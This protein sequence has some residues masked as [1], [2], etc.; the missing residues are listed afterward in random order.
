[1]KNRYRGEEKIDI[2]AM[3]KIDIAAMKKLISRG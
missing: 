2:A 1:M 3:K